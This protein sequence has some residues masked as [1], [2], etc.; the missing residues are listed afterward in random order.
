MK[1]IKKVLSALV[2]KWW[3]WWNDKP[4]MKNHYFQYR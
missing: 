3:K 2:S 1:L 4:K